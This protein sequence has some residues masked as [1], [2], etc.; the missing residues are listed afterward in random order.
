LLLD[1]PQNQVRPGM[2][3][4]V[5]MVTDR[6]SNAIVVPREAVQRGKDGAA[7]MVVDDTNVAHRQ[8][9]E[10]GTS[11]VA[12]VA[13]LKGLHPGDK[14]ITLS[15]TPVKDGQTVR[16]GGAKPESGRRM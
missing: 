11:D 7:V 6:V 10:L 14:V 15:A 8:P 16:I 9:V 13:I 2:F 3:A 12:V 1:N 4:R 5:K